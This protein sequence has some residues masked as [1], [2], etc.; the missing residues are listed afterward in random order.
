MEGLMGRMPSLHYNNMD[1][2]NQYARNGNLTELQSWY[3]H[4]LPWG[5][6]NCRLAAANGQLDCLRYLYEHGAYLNHW[7]CYAAAANGHLTCLQYAHET[8]CPWHVDVCVQAIYGGHVECL[9]YA[10]NNGCPFNSKNVKHIRK[11]NPCYAYL[12][13]HGYIEEAAYQPLCEQDIILVMNQAQ[14]TY[15]VAVTALNNNDNDLVN[16][17]LEITLS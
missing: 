4:G 10:I 5:V 7:T 14:C 15:D 13:G 3:E 17:I 1:N 9:R 16:A 2:T 6:E 11:S 12:L 8:G